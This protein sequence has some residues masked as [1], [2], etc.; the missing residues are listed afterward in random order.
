MKMFMEENKRNKFEA[1]IFTYSE[2][3][4][5]KIFIYWN[6]KQVIILK[7]KKANNFLSRIKN[8]NQLEV[9]LIMAKI[10]GNFKRGNERK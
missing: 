7:D 3:K 10:S 4:E 9:Q 1:T 6:G 2:V 5:G 8:V